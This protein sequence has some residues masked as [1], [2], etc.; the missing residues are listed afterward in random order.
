MINIDEASI[1]K[2]IEEQVKTEVSKR[3][4]SYFTKGY[5]ADI[6]KEAAREMI[7]TQINLDTIINKVLDEEG[8]L[9]CIAGRAAARVQ[10]AIVRSIQSGD[11]D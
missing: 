7:Y 4:N 9:E 2:L 3:I 8:M 10:N 6:V 11:D 5:C 1:Q